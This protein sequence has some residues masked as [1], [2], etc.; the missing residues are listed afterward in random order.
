MTNEISEKI[1]KWVENIG[2]IMSDELPLFV[3]EVAAYGFWGSLIEIVVCIIALIG[4]C[5]CLKYCVD[6]NE[7]E[8]G[9]GEYGV[10]WIV[11]AIVCGLLVFACAMTILIDIAE[12]TKAKCAPKLYVIERFMKR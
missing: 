11:G 2:N 6:K 8:E 9:R 12:M 3:K 10:G 7:R 5:L 4:L 1:V